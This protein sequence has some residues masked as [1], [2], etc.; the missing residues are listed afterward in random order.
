MIPVHPD[1]PQYTHKR[2]WRLQETSLGGILSAVILRS[3]SG[4]STA[5]ELKTVRVLY[6]LLEQG[7]R[8][9][10][11]ALVRCQVVRAMERVEGAEV[12]WEA[13]DESDDRELGAESEASS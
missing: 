12:G 6:D 11:V 13:R 7:F 8:E 10:R 2:Y 1:H 3:L 9:R 5:D 4:P